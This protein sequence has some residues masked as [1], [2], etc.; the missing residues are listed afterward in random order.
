MEYFKAKQLIE[1]F[2]KGYEGESK[3]VQL[4]VLQTHLVLALA[5]NPEIVIKAL[6]REVANEPL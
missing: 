4:T 5:G 6:E 1:D 3:A 2:L